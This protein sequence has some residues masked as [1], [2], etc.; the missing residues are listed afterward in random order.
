MFGAVAGAFSGDDVGVVHDPVD[1]RGGDGG[2]AE[3]LSPAG[4]RQIGGQDDRRFLVSGGDQLEEQVGRLGVEG[5]V[6]DFVDDDE[7]VAGDLAQLDL[8]DRRIYE[9]ELIACYHRRLLEAGVPDAPAATELRYEHRIAA[10]WCFYIGWLTTPMENYGWEINVANQIRLATV[11]RD[12]DSKVLLE[13]L[14]QS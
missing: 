3:Y 8:E 12:L 13:A 2:L 9:D 4:E 5:N 10:A 7:P 14:G 6:A 1:H 11:Y